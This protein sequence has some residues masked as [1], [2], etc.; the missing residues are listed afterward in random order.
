MILGLNGVEMSGSL[1]RIGVFGSFQPVFAGFL[2][3]CGRNSP[4]EPN[5]AFHVVDQI[6]HADLGSGPCDANGADE[7]GHGPFLRSED[8]LDE[9]TDFRFPAV[10][11]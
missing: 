3:L 4:L 5:Q 9:G 8:M 11:L 10:R 6:G 1:E 7:Q 2:P